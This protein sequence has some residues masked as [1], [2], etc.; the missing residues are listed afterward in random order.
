MQTEVPEPIPTVELAWT[1]WDDRLPEGITADNDEFVIEARQLYRSAPLY[2]LESGTV[3]EDAV[4]FSTEYGVYTPWSDWGNTVLYGSDQ[5]EVE[6]REVSWWSEWSN[7][8]SNRLTSSNSTKVE[9][10]EVGNEYHT[11]THTEYRSQTLYSSTQYRSRTRSK[12]VY[13]YKESE[14]SEFSEDFIRQE[15]NVLVNM[16]IQY[17]YAVLDEPLPVNPGMEH[18]PDDSIDYSGHYAD[19]E[20]FRWYGADNSGMLCTVDRIG[21]LLPDD[22]MYF[23]PGENVTIGE[24]I[25]A[26]VIIHR[27]YYGLPGLLCDYNAGYDL[28]YQYAQ[29]EGL[30]V[31][32]EFPNLT[33]EA[34]RQEMAYLFFNALPQEEWAAINDIEA[35]SDMDMSRKYYN[36]A[37]QMARAGVISPDEGDTFHPEATATRAQTASIIDK[38]IYPENRTSAG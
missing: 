4:V 16:K 35:L 32:G 29:A 2:R 5:Q 21:V 12:V 27:I 11:I 33:K 6:S 26:A 25:R 13:Y 24:I 36:C 19:V 18:F 7:W 17:R 9:S 23:H 34:T 28:Y 8:T 3:P 22:F 10:R 30:V 31:K 15:D 20:D 37:L 38:L 1:G 14:W